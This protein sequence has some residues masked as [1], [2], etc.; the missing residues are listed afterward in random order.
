MRPPV[1]QMQIEDHEL[2]REP[3]GRERPGGSETT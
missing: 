2:E 1:A 3:T